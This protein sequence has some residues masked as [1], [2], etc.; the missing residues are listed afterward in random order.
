MLDKS[1]VSYQI[2]LTKCDK[3]K[4]DQ[5]EKLIK[6]TNAEISGHVAAHPVLMATSSV[7][8]TG[9]V[10]LRATLATLTTEL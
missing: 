3:I 2:I 8:G 9:I 6:E 4:P 10:T 5:L 7:N 1:A